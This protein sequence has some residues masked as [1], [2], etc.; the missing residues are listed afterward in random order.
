MEANEIREIQRK[1][2]FC[3][4]HKIAVP[5]TKLGLAGKYYPDALQL[6]YDSVKGFYYTVEMVD[7]S[8]TRSMVTCGLEDADWPDEGG[9]YRL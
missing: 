9:G 7:E 1:I 2:K 6:R 4:A 5:L 8:L 3:M